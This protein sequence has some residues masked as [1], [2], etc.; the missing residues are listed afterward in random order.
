[1]LW[2]ADQWIAPIN[3]SGDFVSPRTE[4]FVDLVTDTPPAPT[5]DFDPL[6]TVISVGLVPQC[7]MN[8]SR[9]SEG[10]DLA[11]SPSATPC[12]CFFE[13]QVGTAPAACVVCADDTPCGGGKCRHGFCEARS[14][15][16]KARSLSLWAAF[17]DLR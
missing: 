13:S 1:V 6:A 16:P 12:D 10:G 2:T 3:G 14:N 5:P 8:V 7:S 17:G 11:L 4:Y 15:L 9:T